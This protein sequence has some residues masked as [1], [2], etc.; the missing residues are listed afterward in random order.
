MFAPIY[1]RMTKRPTTDMPST[2]KNSLP[3]HKSST[4]PPTT[5]LPTSAPPTHWQ[6]TT[7]P[8][9]SVPPTDWP[10]SYCQ[11]FDRPTDHQL[12]DSPI[13]LQLTTNPSTRQTYFNR[14]TIGPIVSITNFN[15]S[16]KMGTIYPWIHKIIHKMIG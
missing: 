10:P 12:T 2:T 16:I 1:W 6:L 9:T 3:T 5:D 4:N 11:V 8:A 13:L 14:V 15:S 7:D